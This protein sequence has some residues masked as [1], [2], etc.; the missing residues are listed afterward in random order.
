MKKILT[1]L[2]ACIILSS[3]KA[4]N[5]S[6]LVK[7]DE[8]SDLVFN[9][10]YGE[11]EVLEMVKG[12]YYE[13]MA[14]E[15][16]ARSG[17]LSGFWGDIWSIT[18]GENR[19]RIIVYYNSDGY[20]EHVKIDNVEADTDK[21]EELT[22][23]FE[24]GGNADYDDV[25]IYEE[26]WYLDDVMSLISSEDEDYESEVVLYMLTERDF[27][28]EELHEHWGTPDEML[29]GLWGDIW[30]IG[31][32]KQIVVY[33]N[34][35]GYVENVI[36]DHIETDTD[37]NNNIEQT[38][39]LETEENGYYAGDDITLDEDNYTYEVTE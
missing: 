30:D 11:A 6:K 26:D 22:G 2:I 33:Y 27:H 9:K 20:A 5:A 38:D 14:A 39:I 17:V 37:N 18:D 32:N 25:P 23:T 12:V 3:C 35:D 31:N 19:K 1:V 28:C 4:N 15:W 34:S 29:S 24:T 8:V 36:I 10:G 21:N 7:L 13:D 16:G